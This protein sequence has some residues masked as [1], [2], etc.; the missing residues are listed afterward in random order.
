MKNQA[1]GQGAVLDILASLDTEINKLSASGKAYSAA[2]LRAKQK[3][4]AEALPGGAFHA[5]N[6]CWTCEPETPRKYVPL[7]KREG[8]IQTVNAIISIFKKG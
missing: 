6:E 3:E 2:V 5:D 7:T 4:L 1:V 8:A